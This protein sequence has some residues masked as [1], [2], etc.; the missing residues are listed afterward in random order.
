MDPFLEE[1]IQTV[2]E[3]GIVGM[4]GMLVSILLIWFVCCAVIIVLG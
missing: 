4:A 1:T 2:K 3:L